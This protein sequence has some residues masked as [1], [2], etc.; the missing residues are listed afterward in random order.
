MEECFLYELLF[1]Y[2]NEEKGYSYP[3]YKDLMRD[4]RTNRKA[5]ISNLLKS[6]VDKG[7][8]LKRKCGRR[9]HYF[10]KKFIFFYDGENKKNYDLSYK[11]KE[12]EEENKV[13]DITVI[14]SEDTPEDSKNN[15]PYY[16]QVHFT[17]VIEEDTEEYK[18][19]TKEG[20]SVKEAHE[21]LKLGKN[22]MQRI[23]ESI[24]YARN[25]GKG[26]Q[27]KYIKWCIVNFN[28]ILKTINKNK[29]NRS[30]KE[31]DVNYYYHKN[32]NKPSFH[33]FESRNYDY[34]RLEK[35]LLGWE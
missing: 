4:L 2:Y 13:I 5:K 11:D 16:G 3:S 31:E 28:I 15:K 1:D 12:A 27:F 10:L 30:N 32:Y 34:D 20:F 35:K 22:N 33:N 25:R 23:K 26:D 17:E 18:E 29:I 24:K 14:N 21:F 19:L 7:F 6:L 9:N 8:V